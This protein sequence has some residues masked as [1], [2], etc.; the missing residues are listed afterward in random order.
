MSRM[1]A[2]TTLF[3]L[4]KHEFIDKTGGSGVI[5]AFQLVIANYAF[6][7]VTS[8]SYIFGSHVIQQPH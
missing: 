4:N 2:P 1:L 3:P 8:D 6:D 7:L 5:T